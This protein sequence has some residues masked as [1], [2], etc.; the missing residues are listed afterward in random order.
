MH[1]LPFTFVQFTHL[2]LLF[3]IY[4]NDLPKPLRIKY[5]CMHADD[6]SLCHMSS[7]ISELESAIDEDLELLDNWL[8]GNKLSLN[9]A[10]TKSMLI[11]TKSR[12]K[13]LNSNDDKLNLLIR[14]RELESVDVIKYLSVHVD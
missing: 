1:K 10:K 11:C 13:I 8:K 5:V 12:R 7:D 14:N 6:T 4:I 2:P 9:V 3:L